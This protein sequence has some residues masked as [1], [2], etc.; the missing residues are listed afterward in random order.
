MQT[1]S[2]SWLTSV[3]GLRSLML[4]DNDINMLD[5]DALDNLNNIT[6]IN[7]A[8]RKLLQGAFSNTQ[9][10]PD[11]LTQNTLQR[12]LIYNKQK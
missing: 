10:Q 8:G 7:L 12:K 3:P 9:Y 4:M 6:E 11:S 5:T 2:G 1:V